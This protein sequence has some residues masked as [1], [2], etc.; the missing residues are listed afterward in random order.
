MKEKQKCSL[1]E[2][3]SGLQA[4][5]AEDSDSTRQMPAEQKGLIVGMSE[6]KHKEL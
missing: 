5:G 6:K 1:P 3:S 4:A 2:M